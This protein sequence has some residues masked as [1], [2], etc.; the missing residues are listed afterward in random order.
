ML[1]KFD[2]TI[3]G[4]G[5]AGLTAGI[6]TSRAKLSTILLEKETFG[7]YVP[8]IE[9]VDNFTALANISGQQLSANMLAQIRQ[10]DAKLAM[11]EVIGIR[12]END[13]MVIDTDADRFETKAVILAS[14]ATPRKLNIPGEEA[15]FG[16]GVFYCAT[17]DGHQFENKV[18]AVAGGGDSALTEAFNLSKIAAEVVIIEIMDELTGT[19]ILRDKVLNHPKIEVLCGVKIEKI[20]G[21]DKVESLDLFDTE[22]QSKGQLDVDGILVHIGRIP[23]T[24]FIDGLVPLSEEG[25]ILVDEHMQTPVPGIFAAG[26]IRQ[27]SPMQIIS[28]CGD[29]ATAAVSVINRLGRL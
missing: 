13:H 15:L 9:L 26:D 22:S 18:V 20:N 29:G 14:G 12:I 16:K 25:F 10:F 21:D 8:N 2:V 17:C 4:T 3:I 27:H 7:G 19:C 23:G 11:A 1:K 24:G 28:A 6:Y 5:P